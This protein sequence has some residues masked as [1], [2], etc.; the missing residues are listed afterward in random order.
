MAVESC[1]Q[2]SAP[3]PAGLLCSASF[4]PEHSAS[5]STLNW[6]AAS[7]LLVSQSSLCHPLQCCCESSSTWLTPG[8]FPPRAPK[9]T[10]ELQIPDAFHS[11]A[12]WRLFKVLEHLPRASCWQLREWWRCRKSCTT[13]W[14]HIV[15]MPSER[16]CRPC[17][18]A[19]EKW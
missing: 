7:G 15:L 17:Q 16:P 11:C 8:S 14:R 3:A 13:V 12:K 18:P 5:I 2:A 10:R 6:A 19:G 1:C 4:H 9:L